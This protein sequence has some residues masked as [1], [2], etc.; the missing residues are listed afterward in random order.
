MFY[1]ITLMFLVKTQPINRKN[2]TK[3][4][5]HYWDS[6]AVDW[7]HFTCTKWLRFESINLRLKGRVLIIAPVVLVETQPFEK[8]GKAQLNVIFKTAIN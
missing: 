8:R 5:P 2:Y 1:E 7:L 6:R 3:F 4:S